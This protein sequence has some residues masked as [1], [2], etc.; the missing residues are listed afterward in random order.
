[1][2]ADNRV[3]THKPIHVS[4]ILTKEF[5]LHADVQRAWNLTGIACTGNQTPLIQPDDHANVL[6]L[7]NVVQVPA[8][9]RAL[10]DL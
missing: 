4:R 10:D 1:M 8:Q 3:I 7:L 9:Q 5:R 2:T 6:L